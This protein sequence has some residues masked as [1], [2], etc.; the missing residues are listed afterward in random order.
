[1][2]LFVATSAVHVVGGLAFAFVV[3]AFFEVVVG[4]GFEFASQKLPKAVKQGTEY[5][6]LGLCWIV[7]ALLCWAG[8]GCIGAFLIGVD[9]TDVGTLLFGLVMA[10]I[11]AGLAVLMIRER[12]KLKRDRLRAP[13]RETGA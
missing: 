4:A 12:R 9:G 13:Q 10:P 6:L 5:S 2:N 8:F 3:W 7:I 1:M 11:G